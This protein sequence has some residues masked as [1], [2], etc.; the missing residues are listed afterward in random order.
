MFQSKFLVYQRVSTN[1]TNN[2]KTCDWLVVW[3]PLKNISQLGWWHSQ[4]N[5]KIKFMFQ[6]TNQTISSSS[7]WSGQNFRD[8]WCKWPVAAPAPSFRGRWRQWLTW[9]GR[10]I[11]C[12]IRGPDGKTKKK[13]IRNGNKFHSIPFLMLIRNK[14]KCEK[15]DFHSILQL[16]IRFLFGFPDSPFKNIS[17]SDGKIGK[18]PLIPIGEF[19]PHLRACDSQRKSH[20]IV[21]FEILGFKI[22]T[23]YIYI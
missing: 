5:G 9:T 4:L 8:R 15:T 1:W 19:N 23:I 20:Q 6:T 14:W 16:K 13:K 22:I 18:S 21:T 10:S 11:K 2:G 17:F 3:T 7:F 12:G